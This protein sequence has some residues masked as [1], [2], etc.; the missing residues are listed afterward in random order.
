MIGRFALV[1]GVSPALLLLALGASRSVRTLDGLRGEMLRATPAPHDHPEQRGAAQQGA[2]PPVRSLGAGPATT[3]VSFTAVSGLYEL[4]DGR[5]LASDG[6]ERVIHLIDFERGTATTVSREGSGPREYRTPSR[7]VYWAGDS[8]AMYDPGQSRVLVFTPAGAPARSFQLNQTLIFTSRPPGGSEVRFVDANGRVYVQSTAVPQVAAG[9]APPDSGPV[10]R[11]DPGRQQVDTIAQVRLSGLAQ[12]PSGDGFSI[13]LA[14]VANPFRTQDA[15]VGFPDGRI[16][17][18]RSV[19]YRVEW[20]DLSGRRVPGLV[21]PV[22]P[23]PVTAADRRR[24]AE[25]GVVI[26]SRRMPVEE[27]RLTDL[28]ETK[29]AFDHRT[30]IADPVTGTVWVQRFRSASDSIPV[31]DVFDGAGRL[32]SR[33]RVP[34][35]SRVVGFGRAHVYTARIDE[36]DLQWLE[37]FRRP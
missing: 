36:D 31:Y 8:A 25:E 30:L 28:P 26:G 14:D 12:R 11:F 9:Q 34:V 5:V 1:L 2:T 22:T 7:F 32:T 19:P 24:V 13:N 20:L 21:V 16:A 3:E 37:R 18:A 27:E 23:V 17:I 6:R 29:P 33:V 35:R 10:V 15:W 4:A